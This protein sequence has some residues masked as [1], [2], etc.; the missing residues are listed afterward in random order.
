[1]FRRKLHVWIDVPMKMEIEN[2][3]VDEIEAQAKRV[4]NRLCQLQENI[5]REEQK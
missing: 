2:L 4:E 3:T 5:F 1:M